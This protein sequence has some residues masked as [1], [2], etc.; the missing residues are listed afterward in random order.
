MNREQAIE[1]QTHP[2]W[3]ALTKEM[4]QLVLMYTNKLIDA[5]GDDVVRTQERIKAIRQCIALP[6]QIA[7]R[8]EE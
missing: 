7:E 4:H 2:A 3:Q 1:I 5:E 8:E 6:E